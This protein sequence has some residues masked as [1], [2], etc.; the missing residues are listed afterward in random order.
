MDDDRS[1]VMANDESGLEYWFEPN[2]LDGETRC[3]W[4]I[5]GYPVR[6][7]WDAQSGYKL[8]ITEEVPEPDKLQEAIVDYAREYKPDVPFVYSGPQNDAVALFKAVEMHLQVP[9]VPGLIERVKRRL[10]GRHGH[11]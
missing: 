7:S 9:R 4:D 3:G 1:I 2:D 5:R 10:L 6:L 8:E 11:E